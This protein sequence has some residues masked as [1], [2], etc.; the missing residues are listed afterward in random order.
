MVYSSTALF[1][2]IKLRAGEIA[3]SVQC[4]LR[5]RLWAW[6]P[7]TCTSSQMQWSRSVISALVIERETGACWPASRATELQLQC[8]TVLEVQCSGFEEDTDRQPLACV[9][10]HTCRAFS[11]AASLKQIKNLFLMHTKAKRMATCTY[12]SP[13][14]SRYILLDLLYHMYLH[15]SPQQ[16]VYFFNEFQSEWSAL[17]WF[18]IEH[19]SVYMIRSI[20]E[21]TRLCI[22]YAHRSKVYLLCSKFW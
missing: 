9:H 8:D 18:T 2:C 13:R 19:F 22:W 6:L 1:S 11:S 3:Q 5:R 12:L 16:S 10:I 20:F 21:C 15:H 7:G 17:V 14:F 4:L